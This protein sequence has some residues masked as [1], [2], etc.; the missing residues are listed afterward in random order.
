MMSLVKI[1]SLACSVLTFSVSSLKAG[2]WF[3]L[4]KKAQYGAARQK[5][6]HKKAYYEQKAA[7]Y[8]TDAKIQGISSYIRQF[9]PHLNADIV[10][11]GIT[12]FFTKKQNKWL[13]RS[14]DIRDTC[15]LKK[16]F[17]RLINKDP[18]LGEKSLGSLLSY[19]C[20]NSH[21]LFFEYQAISALKTIRMHHKIHLPENALVKQSVAELL[22]IM[23]LDKEIL[24][25]QALHT[26]LEQKKKDLL[27]I[28]TA[29]ISKPYKSQ[30]IVVVVDPE[31]QQELQGQNKPWDIDQQPAFSKWQKGDP[32]HEALDWM[33]GDFMAYHAQTLSPLSTIHRAYYHDTIH[34]NF[35]SEMLLEYST[36]N[37]PVIF[38]C[39][40][41]LSGLYYDLEK[42]ND[43][44]TWWK[45]NPVSPPQTIQSFKSALA[46]AF[47]NESSEGPL[48]PDQLA[49]LQNLEEETYPCARKSVEDA[50][51]LVVGPEKDQTHLLIPGASN[52]RGPLVKE[53]FHAG[54]IKILDEDET[55]DHALI[56]LNYDFTT[57]ALVGDSHSAGEYK[58]ITVVVPAAYASYFEPSWCT[59]PHF[60]LGGH[61]S[62]TAIL[63]AVTSIV[64]GHYPDLTH[65]EIRTAILQGANKSFTGYKESLHGQ[66]MLN[67][68]GALAV[69]E[70]IMAARHKK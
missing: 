28:E 14:I 12:L 22:Q 63:S 48:S 11:T 16:D 47:P 65:T 19:A 44:T 38:S 6:L 39:S 3:H 46:Q 54:W 58:E 2:E 10:E 55:K 56:A 17:T 37:C 41:M 21:S 61:S 1:I 68:K 29:Q 7:D 8:L 23:K 36:M 25:L 27:G 18:T 15:Q 60:Y 53:G 13:K 67:L 26:A 57:G 35:F 4:A 59:L 9:F 69:A 51:N 31:F 62:A 64:R 50:L 42:K 43:G 32:L 70:K 34:E 49:F 52:S 45:K 40:F 66:G 20:V 5:A 30:S 24:K 33:H